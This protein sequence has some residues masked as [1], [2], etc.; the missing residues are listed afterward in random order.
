MNRPVNNLLSL[1]MF[2]EDYREWVVCEADNHDLITLLVE[3]TPN[4]LGF[5]IERSED[6]CKPYYHDNQE[7]ISRNLTVSFRK[8][9]LIH[10]E[11]NDGQE[12]EYFLVHKDDIIFWNDPIDVPEEDEEECDEVEGCE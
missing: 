8:E 12:N 9:H 11:E 7:L 2:D 10:Y 4:D 3:D 5:L 1:E 6:G